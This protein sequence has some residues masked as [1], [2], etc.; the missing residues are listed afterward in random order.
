MH[1]PNWTILTLLGKKLWIPAKFA[2]LGRFIES[3][4][5]KSKSLVDLKRCNFA[6]PVL[7]VHL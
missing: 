5:Y 6:T 4:R 2:D 3:L 7:V 1:I